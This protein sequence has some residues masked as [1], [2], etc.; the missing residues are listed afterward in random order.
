MRTIGWRHVNDES[1]FSSRMLDV[2]TFELFTFRVIGPRQ[3]FVDVQCSVE[4]TRD[5]DEPPADRLQEKSTNQKSWNIAE[6]KWSNVPLIK[7]LSKQ[8]ILCSDL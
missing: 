7:V 2:L 3:T 4:A 5:E 1:K 8:T 6:T